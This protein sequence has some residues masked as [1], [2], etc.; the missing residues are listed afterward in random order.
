MIVVFE[1][2]IHE[3]ASPEERG[4]HRIHQNRAEGEEV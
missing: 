1:S 3:V 4:I 2:P